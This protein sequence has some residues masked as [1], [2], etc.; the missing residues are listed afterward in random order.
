MQWSWREVRM[1]GKAAKEV[2]RTSISVIDFTFQERIYVRIRSLKIVTTTCT[3][4]CESIVWRVRSF[5]TSPRRWLV[6]GE[7]FGASLASEGSA[8]A[9]GLLMRRLET[10]TCMV[11]PAAC[12]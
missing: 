3:K 6:S 1:V 8:C 9:E 11:L 12:G 2:A 7:F 10:K 4:V 5:K